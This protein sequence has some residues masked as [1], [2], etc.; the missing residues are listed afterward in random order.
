[1]TRTDDSPNE[2]APPELL[3]EQHMA[4][5]VDA[6]A[7]E[8]TDRLV[9]LIPPLLNVLL[10][11]NGPTPFGWLLM[12]ARFGNEKEGSVHFAT[13]VS[14]DGAKQ[15]VLVANTHLGFVITDNAENSASRH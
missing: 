14:E 10:R 12:G 15:M 13:N 6:H 7:T 2:P 3:I 1:M 8:D 11:H 9:S 5:I 4:E